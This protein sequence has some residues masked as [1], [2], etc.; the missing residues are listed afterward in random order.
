MR[1]IESKVKRRY[2]VGADLTCRKRITEKA[3]EFGSLKVYVEGITFSVSTLSDFS[4]MNIAVYRGI[5][6]EIIFGCTKKLF[7]FVKI[8][9]I[10]SPVITYLGSTL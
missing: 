2:K 9:K 6:L 4:K 1:R 7:K 3:L 10:D 8:G 5:P